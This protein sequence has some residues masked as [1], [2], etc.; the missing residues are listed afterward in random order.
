MFP[1]LELPEGAQ[2]R[3]GVV[4]TD[5]ECQETTSLTGVIQRQQEGRQGV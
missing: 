3:V 4:Q 2:V 5:L 1:A